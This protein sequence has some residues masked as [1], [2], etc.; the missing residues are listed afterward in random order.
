MRHAS[1]GGISTQ[2]LHNIIR[3]TMF[4]PHD[5]YKLV[6]K[7]DEENM[8]KNY[9]KYTHKFEGQYYQWNDS[10]FKDSVMDQIKEILLNSKYNVVHDSSHSPLI[11]DIFL[12][13]PLI[14]AQNE[15]KHIQNY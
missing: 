1:G 11:F 3:N 10:K 5:N 7:F 13:R 14:E 4:V 6:V 2:E 12:R 15:S 9:K 8:P